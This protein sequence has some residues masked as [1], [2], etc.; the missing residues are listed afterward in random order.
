MAM[1]SGADDCAAVVEG[2]HAAPTKLRN[3]PA[4]KMLRMNAPEMRS[5]TSIG[6]SAEKEEIG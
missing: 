4:T 2:R 1:R 3:S 6:K 5:H